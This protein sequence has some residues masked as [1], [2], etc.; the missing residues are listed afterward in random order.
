MNN[1]FF[2]FFQLML[3]VYLFYAAFNKNGSLYQFP[4][5]PEETQA[6][7]RPKLKT[8]FLSAGCIA[9]LDGVI[10]FLKNRMFTVT[11]TET[12]SSIV[13]NFEIEFLPFLSYGLLNTISTV[14]TVLLIAFFIGLFIWLRK[15][16][17]G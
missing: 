10:S 11:V 6:A 2:D 15:V 14:L 16:T 12:E 9:L 7:I 3:A 4:D 8:L 13:Q 17:K 1:S 5:L